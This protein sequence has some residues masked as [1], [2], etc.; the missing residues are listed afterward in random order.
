MTQ[1][2]S[3]PGEPK[4]ASQ[5]G[6]ARAAL[7]IGPAAPRRAGRLPEAVLSLLVTLLGLLFVTFIIGR[8]IPI[9]PV[10]AILGDRATAAQEAAA[11]EALSLDRPLL[12]QF[13]IYLRDVL[14][15]NFGKSLL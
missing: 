9:D 7:S 14:T 2:I 11:R 3:A 5:P 10:L 15:G 1:D 13:A 8:V 6:P 4:L 12:V